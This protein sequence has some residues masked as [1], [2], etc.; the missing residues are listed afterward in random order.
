MTKHYS[1]HLSSVTLIQRTTSRNFVHIPPSCIFT[2]CL[3]LSLCTF[4]YV[5]NAVRARY[6]CFPI[7]NNY[8]V[9]NSVTLTAVKVTKA[10]SMTTD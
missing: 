4:R 10:R 3:F 1:V 6:S 9:V 7:G 8:L 5:A 2:P